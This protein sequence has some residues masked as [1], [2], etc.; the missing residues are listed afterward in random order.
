MS[1]GTALSLSPGKL[2]IHGY[3]CS[4]ILL[5]PLSLLAELARL[6]PFY[7]RRFGP[8]CVSVRACT[9]VRIWMILALAACVR[10]A[11]VAAF[12]IVIQA[13]RVR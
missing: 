1:H 13:I 12:N 8:V 2:E 10:M 9:S 5:G 6:V 3:L 11:G 4:P 7:N